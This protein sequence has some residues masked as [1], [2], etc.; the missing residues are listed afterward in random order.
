MVVL[1]GTLKHIVLE[2][3]WQALSRGLVEAYRIGRDA[4]PLLPVYWER[5]WTEPIDQVRRRYQV[6]PCTPAYVHG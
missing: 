6:R 2:Q 4:A 1:F 3:R 5:L